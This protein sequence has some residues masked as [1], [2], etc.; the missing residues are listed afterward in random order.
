[1]RPTVA[2]SY[3]YGGF[4]SHRLMAEINP[5]KAAYHLRIVDRLL[6]RRH[7]IFGQRDKLKADRSKER[8]TWG[9]KPI[10]FT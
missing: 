7:R 4:V 8:Q 3:S 6:V 5:D 2:G 9:V 10:L 1:M